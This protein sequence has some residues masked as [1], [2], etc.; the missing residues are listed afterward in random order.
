MAEALVISC[1]IKKGHLLQTSL[2]IWKRTEK[3]LVLPNTASVSQRWR[4]FSIILQQTS[5]EA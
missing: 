1:L 3:K 4:Q 5:K 2:V